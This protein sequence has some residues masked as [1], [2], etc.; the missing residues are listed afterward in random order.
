MA[1]GPSFENGVTIDDDFTNI[2]LYHL[3][4]KLLGLN[5]DSISIDGIDRKD[6]WA[7]MLKIF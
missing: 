3:F 6:V 5:V 7:K 2:D 4:C 1:S